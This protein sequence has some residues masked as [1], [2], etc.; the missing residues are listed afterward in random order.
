MLK[1][2]KILCPIDFSEPSLK[3]LEVGVDLATLFKAKLDV[4]YV[5]PILPATA[6]DA[7]LQFAIPEYERM[8]HIDAEQQLQ[9]VVSQRVSKN[10]KTRT[11]IG[12][13]NPAHEI[14][15]LAQEEKA[16]L[17]VIATHGHTGF[18]HLVVGSVAEKVIR[19]APCPVLAVRE[20]R[21]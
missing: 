20:P 5:L 2:K 9:A 1:I 6:K 14:V 8:I 13:G 12:H 10:L 16:D 7:N 4:V 21:K 3:G 15:R 11:L 17:I 19:L 18:H